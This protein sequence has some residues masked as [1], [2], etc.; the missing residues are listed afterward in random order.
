MIINLSELGF[1]LF[2]VVYYY[3]EIFDHL[4]FSMANVYC[5]TYSIFTAIMELYWLLHRPTLL[6]REIRISHLKI[7]F[8][9]VE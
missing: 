8:L 2:S 9:F 3:H 6:K 4:N 7:T 5:D 1:Q